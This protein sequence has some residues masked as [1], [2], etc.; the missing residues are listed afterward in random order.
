M[1]DRYETTRCASVAALA[2]GAVIAL[3]PVHADAATIRIVDLTSGGDP[4]YTMSDTGAI[5]DAAETGIN[6]GGMTVDVTVTPNESN[7]ESLINT[8]AITAEGS[9]SIRIITSE[10]GF[11]A[12]SGGS[13]AS[14]LAFSI[15][16]SQLGP[17]GVQ[18][19]SFVDDG[20][21][22]EAQT[23][24]IGSDL[25]LGG[26]LGPPDTSTD[27]TVGTATLSDPF[28]ITSVFEIN[29]ETGDDITSFDATAT[30]AVPLPAGIWLML[31]AV[32]GL[33]GLSRW[34]KAA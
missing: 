5:Q 25:A 1:A 27:A 10:D 26:P 15:T 24:Q 8:A 9:G 3:A 7:I 23:T 6:I 18:A 32:G 21:N 19:R 29:H 14:Q 4:D 16:S 12:G 20:N 28:S 31:G 30:A 2:V 17:N 22:T 34:R 11:T 13:I 33:F